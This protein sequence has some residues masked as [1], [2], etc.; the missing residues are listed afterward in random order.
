MIFAPS[1]LP[2]PFPPASRMF[3][4]GVTHALGPLRD[5]QERKEVHVVSWNVAAVNNNPFEYWITHHDPAYNELMDGVQDFLDNPGARDV[6]VH[7]VFTDKMFNQL[8]CDMIDANIAGLK[9]VAKLWRDGFS[10]RKIVSG[11]LKDSEIGKKRLASMPD[12]ITNTINTVGHGVQRRPTVINFFL[13]ELSSMSS[14][15][16]QWR[17][18]VFQCEVEVFKGTSHK[19]PQRPQ[20]IYELLD[21]ILQS[22]YPAVS[23]EEEAISIP[24]QILCLAIFDAILVHM[25]LSVG[26]RTWQ[27]IRESI[28]EA[29][30]L[31][32][33]RKTAHILMDTY[34][35]ADVI[36]LQEAPGAVNECELLTSL[37]QKYFKLSPAGIDGKRDQ[38]SLVL[39]SR[40][41]FVK[42]SVFDITEEVLVTL[43]KLGNGKT[44]RSFVHGDLVACTLQDKEGV[45]FLLASFHGDTN[46]FSTKPIIEAIHKT[47]ERSYPNHKLI[48]GLDANTYKVHSEQ[49]QGV[50]DFQQFLTA[51]QLTSCWG[52]VAD[53]SSP[54]TCNARTYLQPQL[55]KAIGKKDRIA[56][57]DKNLKDWVVFHRGQLEA[58]ST[59]KDNTGKRHFIDDMVFPTMQFPSDHAIVST[60]LSWK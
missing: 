54:T 20:V 57:A 10:R 19:G 29:M 50:D 27:H 24:L 58:A 46:G 56:K 4:D 13:G 55:N 5:G 47:A 7:E 14:W 8:L 16:S 1:P 52:E 30:L 25:M 28:A 15:W 6:E 37:S 49:H 39:C 31:D 23:P 22:K 51:S 42:E 38:N 9:E 53:G 21:P 60:V 59:V 40:T 41:T 34:C 35:D 2:S 12:R 45:L 48:V 3:L 36:F 32:K 33:E 18:F 17:T 26:P 11:F 43:G 44:K